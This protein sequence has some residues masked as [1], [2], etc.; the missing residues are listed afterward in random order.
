MI[1]SGVYKTFMKRWEN[2]QT[3]W[4]ISDLHFGEDDL[5]RAFPN[6]PSDDELVRRINAKCGRKDILFVLGDCGDLEYVKKLRG[7]KVLI[8]GNH[9]TG[10]TKYEREI[11]KR[12]FDRDIHPDKDEIRSIMEREFPGWSIRIE[13]ENDSHCPFK[14]WIAYADNLLFDEVYEGA[15]II[16][17]KIILSHEPIAMI[18]WAFNFHGHNHAQKKNAPGHMNVC[19]DVLGYEPAHLNSLLNG[20]ITSKVYTIHRE[21][22]D[23]AT[24]RKK[25]RGGKKI[26]EK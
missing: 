25:K 3:A 10:A 21:T 26:G 19:A 17:E 6:R 22:I 16:G 2:F 9:D 13:E 11:V 8:M 5:K 1:L 7:Y 24:D 15:L 23:N 12:A 4:I 14:R 20:G 18:P